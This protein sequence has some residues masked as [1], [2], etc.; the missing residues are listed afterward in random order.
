MP[1]FRATQRG[2]LYLPR[3]CER[4]NTALWSVLPCVRYCINA[5]RSI[6]WFSVALFFVQV[7]V[8]SG[9]NSGAW[10][11]RFHVAVLCK[12]QSWLDLKGAS[13]ASL[14]D[15]LDWLTLIPKATRHARNLCIRA[16]NLIISAGR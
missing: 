4:F 9:D 15:A 2:K 11:G 7:T 14:R 5:A 10:C 13:H 12:R 16:S 8:V 3:R 1:F 6:A